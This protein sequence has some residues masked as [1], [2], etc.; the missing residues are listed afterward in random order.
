M[1][2]L[3]LLYTAGGYVKWH[4]GEQFGSFLKKVCLNKPNPTIYAWRIPLTEGLVGYSPQGLKDLDTTE[5]TWH[6][7]MLRSSP[8][9]TGYS[10]KRRESIQ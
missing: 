9:I 5:E 3:E 1:E 10:P 7:C 6:T 4:L 2:E 8:S